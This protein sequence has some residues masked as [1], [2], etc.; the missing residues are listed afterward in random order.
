MAPSFKS[1]LLVT[2][3]LTCVA[4]AAPVDVRAQATNPREIAIRHL[5][6]NA[7]ALGLTAEDLVG[8]VVSD[9]YRTAH[10]GITHVHFKQLLDGIEVA[11]GTINV[12]VTAD[13]S[14]LSVGNRFVGDLRGK[15]TVRR[16]G[17]T[18]ET[19]IFQAAEQLGL[20]VSGSLFEVA[21]TGG[22]SRAARFSP[23]GLSLD[24]IPVKLAYYRLDDGQV[25]LAWETN[26]RQVDQQHWWHLWVDAVSGE[27]LARNDWIARDSYEVFAVPKESPSDGSRTIESDPADAV[28]SPF[29]WHDTDGSAGAEFTTT[30]GNNVC[31]Q[32]DLDGNNSS[33]GSVAQP[34][35][36]AGLAFTAPLDL[37]TQQPVDY[38]DAAVINLFYWNNVMHDLLY[39]YGFDEASGNFQENNYGRGGL[40]SDSVN[41]DAQDGSGTNNANFSTPPEPNGPFSTNPRMQMFEWTS[42][43]VSELEVD[44][45]STA[46]GF[47][48][49]SDAEFGPALDGTG[50]SGSLVVANDGTG[51]TS[52]ACEALVNGSEIS[53]SIALVDRG[54]CTFVVK[55]KNA[56]DAGAV[57]VVMVNNVAGNP[58][59]MG[60]TDN[61]ITIPSMMIS[62][63]DGNAVKIGLPA[64]GTERAA[65]NPPPNRD[66]DLDAGIIAHEYCHGLSIRLTGGAGNSS[67]LS[68]NQQAGEGWSDL[69]TLFFTADSGDTGATPRGVGTYSL[70]EPTDGT[71]IRPFPYSTDIGIN[72]L[73]YGELSAG[74]LSVPHG[75][76]TVWATAVWEMYWN[77]VNDPSGGF[78]PD[79]YAGTGGNNTAIQLVIDGLKLQPCNPTF[80]DARDAILAADQANN[81]GANECLIWS[82]FAKRGMGWSAA[83]GGG[84]NSLNVTEAFDLPPQCV[85]GC[86]NGVCEIGEDCDTCPSDCVGGTSSGAICG[87]GV[88]EA[89]DGEDCVSCPSD[90][91]GVQNGRPSNR[92]CCGDGDGANPLSCSDPAC[93]SG[94]WSCTEV[95]AQGGGEY[96]CG[97]TFCDAGEDS[98]SC[99]LDCGGG[100]TSTEP[101]GE[102]T[103]DDGVDN[104]CDA[105]IDCD[106]SDCAGSSACQVADCSVYTDRGSCRGDS[107]C[108]WNNRDGT[109]VAK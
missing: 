29:G 52:D 56:Q 90:C 63:T 5:S 91:N 95:P 69:C 88:C 47:Y 85:D 8:K 3:A 87:N 40:G 105:L 60:G 79:L 73:T 32:Q 20:E 86:G 76:G 1:F 6:D 58:I 99:E 54:S 31:A 15:A 100:C 103:C 97:D 14:V 98:F 30:R 46:D 23:A 48:F 68:G 2:L 4:A 25:R 36:G 55:V 37:A 49:G 17:I 42:P 59:A 28:A 33:C 35:G 11:N 109:C 64:T 65:V 61:T 45:S 27:L 7:R 41:A 71:G 18:A 43:F 39:R 19:A 66:S 16:P 53:G 108:R 107:A 21:S 89:G 26:I 50:V 92:F 10:N 84:S 102:T 74:T 106:D 80:L 81:G 22:P 96:C 12:N 38:Q 44:G 101:G 24:E 83:D 75:V 70:F 62:L 94:G 93:S 13:G 9:E 82:A 104:D 72:P 34:S 77:L 57:G 51:E 67:C 78:D